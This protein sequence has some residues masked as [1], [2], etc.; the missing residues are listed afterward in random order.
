MSKK[1]PEDEGIERRTEASVYSPKHALAGRP[2][3]VYARFREIMERAE[4][5]AAFVHIGAGVAEEMDF[6]F[7]E[8]CDRLASAEAE[9][10][11]LHLQLKQQRGEP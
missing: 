9:V 3:D 8:V 7:F 10:G 4:R 6:M 2:N 11:R 1:L 5:T